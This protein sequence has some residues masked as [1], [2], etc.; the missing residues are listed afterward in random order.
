V[1]ATA[2]SALLAASSNHHALLKALAREFGAT[3]T[4]QTENDEDDGV[5]AKDTMRNTGLSAGQLASLVNALLCPV[6]EVVALTD[7]PHIRA[8]TKGPLGRFFQ[9]PEHFAL[10]QVGP[11][12]KSAPCSLLEARFFAETLGYPVMVKGPHQGAQL[13]ESWG[14]LLGVLNHAKWVH[15]GF[16]QRP[17]PGW[18]K[19]L[20]FA[21]F[22]GVLTGVALYTSPHALL[23]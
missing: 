16:L 7:K 2:K 3:E 9:V 23:L 22:D 18:E 12:G 14:E 4:A 19:C 15:G 11:D 21:A 8:V 1:A 17:L 10:S 20:A 5:S 6:Q 13:C